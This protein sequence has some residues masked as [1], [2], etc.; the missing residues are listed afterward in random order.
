MKHQISR[1]LL[2]S[3]DELP[4]SAFIRLNQ[5]LSNAVAPF[6]AATVWRRVQEGTFPEP[7][8]ISPQVTAWRVGDIREWQKCPGD[9]VVTRCESKQKTGKGGAV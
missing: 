6:S 5:L 3:F 7:V 4:D 9:F 8:R 2:V 1:G